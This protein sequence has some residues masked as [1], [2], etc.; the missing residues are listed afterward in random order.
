M[1]Y[2]IAYKYTF[3]VVSI[4]GEGYTMGVKYGKKV[5]ELEPSVFPCKYIYIYYKYKNYH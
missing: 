5:F 1:F 3:N 2:N 4:L